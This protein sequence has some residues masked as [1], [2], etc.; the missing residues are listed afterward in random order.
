MFGSGYLIV[1][2]CSMS[3]RHNPND[4]STHT[5]KV[6]N[7]SGSIQGT[8]AV[9]DKKITAYTQAGTIGD[10][11]FLDA[12]DFIFIFYKYVMEEFHRDLTKHSE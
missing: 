8:P 3:S 7:K 9:F 5:G 1:V 12:S 10:P 4:T 6:V 11:N 2:T